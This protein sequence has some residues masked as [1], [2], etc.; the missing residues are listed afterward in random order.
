MPFGIDA[1]IDRI[2]DVADKWLVEAES[3]ANRIVD[4]ALLK[5]DARIKNLQLEIKEK[6]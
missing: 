1:A 4:R 6:E 5:A 3:T 2:K